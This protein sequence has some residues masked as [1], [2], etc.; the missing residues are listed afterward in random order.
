MA[1][2]IDDGVVDQQEEVKQEEVETTEAVAEE[3]VEDDVPEKYRGKSAKEIAQMH[4]EAEKLI[5]R[6]GSEVGELRR[7]VDQYITAQATTKQQPQV[8]LSE[9]DFFADPKKAV[10]TAIENHPKI[11][12]AEQLT[13]EMQRAKALQALQ[14]TH[15]DY[16]QIVTDPGFQNWVGSSK[17]R[18]ELLVRADRQY[19]F[20]AANELLSLYKE[21]KGAAAETVKAEKQARSQAVRAATTTVPSGSD[22]AP[23]KK[24][25]RRADIMKLM[26]EDPDRYDAMQ[27]EIMLAYREKRVR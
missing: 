22:E 18:Q 4:M 9:D 25:F 15:P 1:S 19:D 3:Q 8:E 26:Q 7:L 17:V 24:I 14:S 5:G 23:S 13:L 10:E 21:R 2:F 12:Q 6:Q 11:R 27:D 20:D 16:A